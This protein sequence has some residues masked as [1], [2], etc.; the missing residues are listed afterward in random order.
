[1]T[2]ACESAPVKALCGSGS[3]EYAIIEDR[4]KIESRVM[5]LL[6]DRWLH[7]VIDHVHI[8]E[9]VRIDRAMCK[10]PFCMSCPLN[11]IFDEI[12]IERRIWP[13]NVLSSSPSDHRRNAWTRSASDCLLPSV[14]CSFVN[15]LTSRAYPGYAHRPTRGTL[16]KSDSSDSPNPKPPPTR[17]N[18]CAPL[19]PRL[20]RR[21]LTYGHC[22]V[23]CAVPKP[24]QFFAGAYPAA[25]AASSV[26]NH[27]WFSGLI[28]RSRTK[29]L[30]DRSIAGSDHQPPMAIP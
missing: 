29:V 26:L 25:S 23:Y 15:P 12:T 5:F 30:V 19:F 22:I 10:R 8:T 18:V 6:I 21:Q 3:E 7:A 24:L 9:R 14:I 16:R 2:S 13:A 17:W 27:T 20:R 1:M 28:S 11:C 4:V